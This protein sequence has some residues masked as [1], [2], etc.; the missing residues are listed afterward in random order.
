LNLL[1]FFDGFHLPSKVPAPAPHTRGDA[2]LS[3]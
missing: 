2:L 3:V 1:D